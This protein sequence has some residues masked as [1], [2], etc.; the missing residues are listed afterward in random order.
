[1]GN[2]QATESRPRAPVSRHPEWIRW[3]GTH[4]L[5]NRAIGL[6]SVAI[7]SIRWGNSLAT[8]SRHRARV[9]R[10]PERI[11]WWGTHKLQNHAISLKSGAIQS[12]FID[13]ELTR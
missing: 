2:S 5:P 3:W 9:S 4:K 13:G 6:V 1:M 8:E 11:R 7:Q 12:G 10:L